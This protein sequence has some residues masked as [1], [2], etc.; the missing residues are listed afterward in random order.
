MPSH[1]ASGGLQGRSTPYGN[2]CCFSF[3]VPWVMRHLLGNFRTD[4]LSPLGCF[5]P[6]LHRHWPRDACPAPGCMSAG[7]YLHSLWPR[8]LWL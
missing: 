3:Y 1:P 7:P 8:R 2:S 5:Q 4:R 6:L